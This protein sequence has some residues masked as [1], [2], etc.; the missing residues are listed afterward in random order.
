MCYAIQ[1]LGLVV[2]AAVCV[3]LIVYVISAA[4]PC[5]CYEG[6]PFMH[7]IFTYIYTSTRDHSLRH[8]SFCS[9]R[10]ACRLY[11]ASA[12]FSGWSFTKLPRPLIS[13]HSKRLDV[14]LRIH[15]VSAPAE[16]RTRAFGE[17]SMA[18]HPIH[19][20]SDIIAACP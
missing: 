20:T 19:F 8:A 12:T 18:F 7:R 2:F 4:S 11:A 3:P 16:G 6:I 1:P 13:L 10:R 9:R 5:H 15:C 14:T 17:C